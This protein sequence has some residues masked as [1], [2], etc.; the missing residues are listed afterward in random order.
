[1]SPEE[2]ILRSLAGKSVVRFLPAVFRGLDSDR[3]AL[4]DFEGGRVPA[5]ALLPL[6][7]LNENVWV[8]LVD[9][10]GYMFGPTV[11]KPD[12]GVV[13]TASGGSATVA[14]DVGTVPARYAGTVSSGDTVR[15][16]WSG[17]GVWILGVTSAFVPPSVPDAPGGGTG[18]RTVE[19]TA[20]DSGSFQ[21]GYGWRTNEV[22]SSSSNMGGWFYGNQ[23]MDTIP[24]SAS[25]VSADIYLPTPTRLL[26]AMPF[27]RHSSPSKPGGALS[28]S[29][30]TTLPATS[31]WVR[32]PNSLIDNLKANPGGLGFDYG[33]YNIWPGTQR[34]GQSGKVRVTFDS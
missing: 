13:A 30:L 10:V 26:G 19:F 33:G 24:D 14:T 6:P 7:G 31:G 15:L 17:S 9:G 32:I 2:L 5:Y 23:I 18:R 20:Q 16:L 29:G 34:D 11:P 4:V 22:W 27:G 8:A 21:S 3:R 25:I 1:M 28:F 12:E